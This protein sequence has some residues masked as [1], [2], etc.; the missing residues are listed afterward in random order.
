MVTLAPGETSTTVTYATSDGSSVIWTPTS[1]NIVWS[2]STFVGSLN[3]YWMALG[4]STPTYVGPSVT[5]Q[6]KTGIAALANPG[7]ELG[8]TAEDGSRN[9]QLKPTTKL[10]IAPPVIVVPPLTSTLFSLL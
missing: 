6:L 7:V 9:I 5:F 2:D 4:F 3:D 10:I 1:P 8:M